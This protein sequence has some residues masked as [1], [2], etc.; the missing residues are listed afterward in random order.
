MNEIQLKNWSI[1]L[2]LAQTK[3]F[4]RKQTHWCSC[5]D[6]ENYREATKYIDSSI[7]KIFTAL[8]IDLS[9]PSH[10]SEFGEMEDGTHLYMGCYHLTGQLTAGPHCSDEDWH[11]GNTVKVQNFTFGFSTEVTFA[12]EDLSEP[13]LQLNFEAQVPWVLE[14]KPE[15]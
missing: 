4:Y 8:G 5:L 7:A 9:K 3:T 11:D 14:E 10:L 1:A 2:D 6:C 12:H 15:E 13:V